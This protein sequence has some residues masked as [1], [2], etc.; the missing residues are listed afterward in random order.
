MFKDLKKYTYDYEGRFFG[1]KTE[2]NAHQNMLKVEKNYGEQS[3]LNRA[4]SNPEE[5]VI[6][7]S[8]IK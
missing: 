2:E 4:T 8:K 1:I 6:T 7:N 5:K 3:F